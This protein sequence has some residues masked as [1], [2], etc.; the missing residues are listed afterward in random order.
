M[1]E[2]LRLLAAVA[3]RARA[4]PATERAVAAAIGQRKAELLPIPNDDARWLAEVGRTHK[5]ELQSLQ[6][7]PSPASLAR[8]FDTHLVLCLGNGGEWYNVHP[9]IKEEIREQVA[10]LDS[11]KAAPRVDIRVGHATL[12]GNT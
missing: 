1:R 11:R 8:F 4:L 6:V 10:A 12:A 2:L 5:A 3:L 9:L 7:R